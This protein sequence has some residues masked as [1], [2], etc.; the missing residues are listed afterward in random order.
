[1]TE[2]QEK[3]LVTF[4]V[5]DQFCE[6]N[7]LMYF[8]A[9]GTC[10]GAVRHHGFIPWDD[11]MDVFMMRTD[12]ERFLSLRYKLIDTSYCIKDFKDGDYPL[13]F[14]KFYSTDSSI[15]EVRK[16]PYI[17]GPW[18]DIFPIDESNDS[19]AVQTLYGDYKSA[20]LKYRR[21]LAYV[22]WDEIWFYV[23]YGKIFYALTKTVNK[24]FYT[25]L[26]KF[27][28]KRILAL[29]NRIGEIHG[30]YYRYWG[31]IIDN[32]SYN[33]DWFSD[34]VNVAF[35]DTFI[36]CPIGYHEYLTTEYGDYMTLPPKEQRQKSHPCLYIDLNNKK[37]IEEILS[38]IKILGRNLYQEDKPYTLSGILKGLIH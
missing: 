8:A 36:S 23:R 38:E 16:Y 19:K 2:Y 26:K 5:F 32:K 22:S 33:K 21:A 3:L 6:E 17:V 12:Y 34:I 25:P 37:T 27:Y 20:F 24:C 31:V 14:A 4:K 9:F 11:D 1:M 15:W 18:I 30:P 7:N 29:I 10:L 28:Y 13:P 35:E